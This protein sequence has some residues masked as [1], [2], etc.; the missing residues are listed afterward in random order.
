[1]GDRSRKQV[2]EEHRANQQ[3][4]DRL[5]VPGGGPRGEPRAQL[6][7][8]P[9]DEELGDQLSH[10]EAEQDEADQQPYADSGVS[11]PELA[12]PEDIGEADD[13]GYE[14]NDQLPRAEAKAVSEGNPDIQEK[15]RSPLLLEVHQAPG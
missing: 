8:V 10:I 1:M 7:V 9:A 15:Q 6:G 13:A 11:L 14:R 4:H 5:L 2:K 12:L 3:A